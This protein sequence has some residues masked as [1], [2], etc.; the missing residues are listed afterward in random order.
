MTGG[1]YR[2]KYHL[3][4]IPGKNITTCDIVP[5]EVQREA[6]ARLSGYEQNKVEKKRTAKAMAAPMRDISSIGSKN[7]GVGSN[8]SS[9]F[10]PRN[11]PGAQPGLLGTSWNK[12]VHQQTKAAMAR[13]WFYNNIPFSI[14]ESPYW[15]QT[16]NG[17]TISCKGFKSLSRYELN[18]PLLQHELQNTHQLVEQQRRNWER[19]NCT[20]LSDGWTDSR[21]GTLINSLVASGGQVVFLKSIDASD[22]VKNAE[23]L[24]NTLDEVVTE[25]GVQ[26]VV[27][28]VTDNAAAYVA[29]VD[30]IA[31]PDGTIGDIDVDAFITDDQLDEMEREALEWA[32]EVAE[33][34]EAGD[35]FADPEEADSSPIEDIA[36]A[37]TPSTSAPTQQQ[38]SFLSFS[39]RRNL[40]FPIFNDMK[41]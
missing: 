35:E 8:T 15:E 10:I 13:F 2:L 12:E 40:Q 41:P 1:I 7:I 36:A 4:K 39:C 34:E 27:Q 32:A 6:K 9:F 18:G 14:L 28:V 11:T 16:V 20:I 30:W 37:A 38:Q 33:R 21:N 5:E 26:N 24:C 22:Q 31:E 17:L 19:N 25:V 23:T 29:A 3:A